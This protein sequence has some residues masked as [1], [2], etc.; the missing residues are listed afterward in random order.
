MVTVYVGFAFPQ[1]I[2]IRPIQQKYIVCHMPIIAT[3]GEEM[4]II[5]NGDAH[6]LPSPLTV[7][8]LLQHLGVDAQQ[9]AVELSGDIVMRSRFDT[10]QVQEGDRVELVEF[11]GGG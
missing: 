2:Q 5:I 3:K 4:Q 6:T 1:H 10:T 8:A 9:I 11:V 7:R